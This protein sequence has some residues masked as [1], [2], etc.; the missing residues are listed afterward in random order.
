MRESNYQRGVIT[1]VAKQL[2]RRTGRK[3]RL[4][5]V[6]AWL[7]EDPERRQQ[8]RFGVGLLLVQIGKEIIN[9]AA[10]ESKS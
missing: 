3:V 10:K 5:T 7:H 2:K 8:P 4:Q 9:H 1:E 6:A